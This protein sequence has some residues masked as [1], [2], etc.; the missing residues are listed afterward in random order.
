MQ[1]ADFDYD[2]PADL[3]AQTPL[4][5]RDRSRLLTLRR[6]DGAIAHR[7]FVELVDHLQPGDVLVLNNSKVIRAR[8]RGLKRDSQ[9]KVEILLLEENCTNDWWAMLRPGRRLSAGTRIQLCRRDGST[10]ECEA[11][12]IGK[13]AEGHGRL[14][15]HRTP[16]ITR[17]L[18]ALG[19]I[20]LPPYIERSNAIHFDD[21]EAR[22][23]TV[24]ARADGSVAA[25]TAGLHFTDELLAQLKAKGVE[26]CF[27][28]LH[29]GVGTFAPVKSEAIEDHVMHSERFEIGTESARIINAAKSSGRRVI[30]A[31][32]T[33]V[34]VLE[35]V[36]RERAGKIE[37]ISGRTNIFIYPPFPFRLVDGL[38]TN[39]HLPKSTLLM[40]VSA[41]AASG[42]AGGR[43]LV[44]CAYAEAIQQRYRFFSYG[45]AMLIE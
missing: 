7:R 42:S 28:T 24:Y 33:T 44:L 37:A 29:V 6:S 19:E 34:R 45:D 18:V 17:E 3:I 16:D 41:F 5:R 26:V 27:V 38:I 12:V 22:Y 36:A 9:T 4:A 10:S 8:L 25:P 35:S 2:L 23:Q 31:G 40:L 11:E 20:P 21:D 30:A 13:N 32:T 39:F 43:E 1:T 14:Q 15:F